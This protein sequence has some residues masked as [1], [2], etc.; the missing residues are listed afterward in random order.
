MNN[1]I[2]QHLSSLLSARYMGAPQLTGMRIYFIARFSGIHML[3]SMEYGGS[4]PEPL[5]PDAYPLGNPDMAESRLFHVIP[6]QSRILV[7]LDREGDEDHRPYWIPLQGGIPQPAITSEQPYERYSFLAATK[8][9]GKLFFAAEHT[10]DGKIHLLMLEPESGM[11]ESLFNGENELEIGDLAL[12]EDEILLIEQISESESAIWQVKTTA[13]SPTERSCVRIF[14]SPGDENRSA[15]VRNAVYEENGDAVLAITS[16][17]DDRYGFTRIDLS[18]A[19][20]TPV[21]DIQGWAE[22]GGGELTNLVKVRESEYLVV[23]NRDEISELSRVSYDKAERR[24]RLVQTYTE[25]FRVDEGFVI[26]GLNYHEGSN[27]AVMTIA[28]AGLPSQLVTLE[29]TVGGR[30]VFHTRE[31]LVGLEK[32]SLAVSEDSAFTS[33]DGTTIPARLYLPG[34]Q[35]EAG[36][37]YP[38]VVYIHGGPHGQERPD[39]S[40]FSMPLIQL[41]TLQ[42]IAVFVPN[43]RGSTGY[44]LNYAAQVDRD[45]GGKDMLDHIAGIDHLSKDPRLDPQRIGVTGR[46]YGGYMTLMLASRFPERWKAA[47][48]MFGPY[49]LLT[50]SERIPLSWRPYMASNLGDPGTPEGREF[51]RD[52]SP[53]V[54]IEKITCPLL[55]IQGANDSR[56]AAQES[57]DLVSVLEAKGNQVAYLEFPDEGHDIVKLENRRKCYAEIA[58][59]FVAHLLPAAG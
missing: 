50:F 56:V 11:V 32:G 7:L 10:E 30:V 36:S 4:V 52:R 27:R 37:P 18:L 46:S 48:D 20:A 39:W 58:Q 24:M 3:Y 31:K 19:N 14:P 35:T 59:F 23:G 47:V 51:L 15:S 22:R 55:V 44:G 9:G 34:P 38:V 54:S 43:V 53:S 1:L 5:L 40:W 33:F 13:D 28:G 6:E 26:H 25:H 45:W 2:N 41:L 29:C 8:N 16:R 12:H 57:R 17:H 42:G 21:A 49:D